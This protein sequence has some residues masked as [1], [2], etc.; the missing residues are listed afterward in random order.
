[1]KGVVLLCL[2]LFSI[3]AFDY[4]KAG[5]VIQSLENELR[6]KALTC[7][8]DGCAAE[9]LEE[10][11]S[12]FNMYSSM[13][14]KGQ[15][16][17]ELVRYVLAGERCLKSEGTSKLRRALRADLA[18]VNCTHGPY[19]V[20][21]ASKNATCVYGATITGGITYSSISA[22]IYSSVGSYYLSSC[23]IN[24]S[25]STSFST[26]CV[27]TIPQ[28]APAG[29]YQVQVYA[30]GSS[31]GVY[32]Y[33]YFNVSAVA[34]SN[35]NAPP[36]LTF[37]S[38]PSKVLTSTSKSFQ[39][40]FS[41]TDD[42]SGVYNFNIWAYGSMMSYYAGSAYWY[43]ANPVLN[44]GAKTIN[45]TLN[46]NLPTDVYTYTIYLNDKIG[47]NRYYY[48][49]DLMQAGFP[50]NITLAANNCPAGTFQ[51]NSSFPCTACPIGT[52]SPAGAS[53]CIPCPRGYTGS[54][55]G[56]SSCTPCSL[57]WHSPGGSSPCLPCGAGMYLN[58]VGQSP[59]IPCYPGSFTNKTGSTQCDTCPPGHYSCSGATNCT[60]CP[61]GTS[62]YG[63]PYCTKCS[64]G[65]HAP[66]PGSP[67][68]ITC[69]I[70]TYSLNAATT[71]TACPTGLTTLRSGSN[72]PL[73]CA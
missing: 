6:H 51:K 22:S 65:T 61:A 14:G 5:N 55:T 47:W 29:Y 40:T 27:F 12:F 30:G 59:C 43:T 2:A 58:Y 38:A 24:P 26:S 70:G 49:Y 46:S 67:Y 73:A 17:E 8:N 19:N 41:A 3:C 10:L 16:I 62:S 7:C 42:F 64:A 69:Q 35:D 71:C 21:T 50:S 18:W 36:A 45:Y 23:S 63:G 11:N 4:C 57:G 33:D 66:V 20:A 48:S 72:S 32:A 1:M 39:I 25:G 56:Q 54:Q 15:E 13:G 37:F 53:S 9:E 31:A 52:Y 34:G 44:T 60:M 28:N 68:C